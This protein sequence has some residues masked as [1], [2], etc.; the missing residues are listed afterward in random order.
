MLARS[1]LNRVIKLRLLCL[2]SADAG[3][4]LFGA[5]IAYDVG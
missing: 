2:V 1:R 3:S 5:G 4:T